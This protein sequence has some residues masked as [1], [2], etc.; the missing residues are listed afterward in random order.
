[1]RLKYEPASEPLHISVEALSGRLKFMVRRHQFN[2]DSVYLEAPALYAGAAFK[3]SGD[4]APC[5]V[6]PAIL[7]GVVSPDL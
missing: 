4:T 6:T 7:L 5:K 3:G 2:K 1:M